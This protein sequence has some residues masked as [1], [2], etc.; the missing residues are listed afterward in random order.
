M[1]GMNVE[2]QA[3][4][5]TAV[6]KMAERRYTKFK[7]KMEEKNNGAF[8]MKKISKKVKDMRRD[9]KKTTTKYEE[10]ITYQESAGKGK[11]IKLRL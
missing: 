3:G 7:N 11:R 4:V 2:E 1:S 6:K 8:T 10:I 9:T 5:A